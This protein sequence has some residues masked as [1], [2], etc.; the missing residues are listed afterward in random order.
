MKF[1]VIITVY[2][3]PRDYL[4]E[5]INSVLFQEYSEIEI[6]IIDDGSTEQETVTIL[7]EYRNSIDKKSKEIIVHQKPNGGQGS[8]RNA[9]LNLASGDYVLFLD[10]DDYYMST[11]FISDIAEL[12]NESKADVLS[13]QYKEFFNDSVRPQVNT[14]V[15]PRERILNRHR[16][17]ALKVLLSAPRSVFSSATHTKVIKMSLLKENNITALEGISNEDISL[18]A[19]IMLYAKTYDRYNKIIYAYRRTNIN[20]ISTQSRNSLVIAKNIMYQFKFLLSDEKYA[21]DKYILD[22]LSAPYAYWIAK[23][24]SASGQIDNDTKDEYDNCLKEGTVYS[25][26]LKHSSRIHI[27][28]LGIFCK[29]FGLKFTMALL[30]VFLTVNKRHMLSINRKTE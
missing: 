6:I 12:L 21:I 26:V 18:T 19:M 23:M 16:D 24:I 5:C 14:G 22:F 28:V 8:A 13:F 17:E 7:D 9:G 29:I 30:R 20:S 25:Y 10:N 27:R 4:S 11:N 3:T 2:N 1:S 15:L